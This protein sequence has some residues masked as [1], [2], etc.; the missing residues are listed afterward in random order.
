MSAR[1]SFGAA[2]TTVGVVVVAGVS[3]GSASSIDSIDRLRLVADDGQRWTFDGEVD[4]AKAPLQS[5]PGHNAFWFAW[6]AFHPGSEVWGDGPIPGAAARADVEGKCTVPCEEIF[7]GCPGRDCIPPL[8]SP[9]MV[10]ADSAD[11]G[12][13]GG[14][15]MILGVRTSKRTARL[16]AEYPVVA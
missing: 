1:A 11:A 7:Q 9:K 5:V 6:S 10:A 4:T 3:I 15:D 13:L 8:D 14:L 16:S 2:L 12:Y